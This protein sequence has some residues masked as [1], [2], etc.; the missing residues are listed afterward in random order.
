MRRISRRRSKHKQGQ[1]DHVDAWLMS[2]ADMITLL[3]MFFVILVYVSNSKSNHPNPTKNNEP[4]HPWIKEHHGFLKL[5]ASFD[6]VYPILM[7]VVVN[8]NAE[9]NIS[10]EKTVNGINMD[11][12]SVQFFNDGS[13]EIPEEQLPIL[14]SLARV[15]KNGVRDDDQIEVEGYTDDEPLRNSAFSNNWEL[16]AMRATRIVSL[17][18]DEGVKP[19][20]LH[21]ASYAGNRPVVPNKDEQGREITENQMRNQRVMIKIKRN[22]E[23]A[24]GREF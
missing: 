16:A 10:V 24:G 13:A 15:I 17:L 5:G 23:A 19:S 9:R 11:I 4:E 20:Q 7:G 22:P 21:A 14:R 1:G 2:Y 6:E 3:F 18:I 8:N 12:S